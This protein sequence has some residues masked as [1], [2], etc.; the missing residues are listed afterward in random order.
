MYVVVDLASNRI[1]GTAPTPEVGESSISNGKF[2]LPVPEGVGI[3]VDSTSGLF[4]QATSLPGE[5]AS[6]LLARFPMYDYVLWNFFLES[7]DI[8]TLDLSGAAP[9]PT[10]G[11]VVI[12][13]PPTLAPGPVPRC[14]VGRGAGPAPVGVAPNS[15]AILPAH[16]NRTAPSYGCLLTD[17]VDLT[18]YT[19]AP[20]TNEVMIWWKLATPQTGEDVLNGYSSTAG[21]NQPALRTLSEVPQEPADFYCYVSLDDGA[22]WVEARYLEPALFPSTNTDLRIAFVNE[23]SQPVWLVGFAALF[24]DP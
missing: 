15:V 7:S 14:Q 5:I 12:G 4:P 23:G 17:T 10:A 8:A 1:E 13:T 3:S 11:S 24:P 21:I 2:Y 6:E 19:G 22:S 9:Q 18:P 16:T 20:G